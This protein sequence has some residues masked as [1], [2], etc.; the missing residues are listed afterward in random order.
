MGFVGSMIAMAG[1]ATIGFALYRKAKKNDL[2]G[3]PLYAAVGAG[4]LLVI[5]GWALMPGSTETA[6]RGSGATNGSG[7]P[8]E[9]AEFAKTTLANREEAGQLM[10]S[11]M[12]LTLGDTYRT[13]SASAE[14]EVERNGNKITLKS[15]NTRG[16]LEVDFTIVD[17]GQEIGK[18]AVVESLAIDTKMS[19]EPKIMEGAQAHAAL[20][21]LVRDSAAN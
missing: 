9:I 4:A 12:G 6:G 19:A 8:K 21:Q 20:T 13:L 3:R 14:C 15:K 5:V 10:P 16:E 18:V 17:T 7:V 1:L 11:A 2:A